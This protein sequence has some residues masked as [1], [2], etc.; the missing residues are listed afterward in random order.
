MKV[1]MGELN[2]TRLLDLMNAATSKCSRVTAAVAY[3]TQSSPFFEHCLANKIFL[4]FIGLLDED[5]A[6]GVGVLEKLLEAG[7]LAVNPRLIKGHFHSKI[8]WWHGH[9]AYIGSANLTASAWSS[10]VECGVFYEEDEILGTQ[11]QVDLEAQFDYLRA[12]SAPVTKE[13][14]AA[15]RKLRPLEEFAYRA[16]EKVRNAF[17]QATKDIPDHKGLVAAAQP[18]AFTRFTVEWNDTL[19]LLRGLCRDFQRLNKRPGW[20]AQSA[21]PTVHF[22]QFLHAY[23]YVRVRGEREDGESARAFDLVNR[24]Y[25]KNRNN[26]E[27]ALR[28]AADWWASLKEA[29][30]GEDVFISTIA[31]RVQA[32]FEKQ[33]LASWTVDDFKNTFRDVHAFATHARQVRNS[34][35]GLPKDHHETG[36]ERV[37]RLSDWLWAQARDPGQ[38]HIH[39]LLQYLIWGTSPTNMVER[40][41]NV[42]RDERW[43]YERLGPSSLGE[44]IGWARPD[45]FP[46]RNNRTNKALRALGYDVTL[47]SDS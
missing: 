44:A 33:R 2:G 38:H 29:P 16:K 32:A 28:E 18:T 24:A 35:F 10:N 9:G 34:V 6:V 27:A 30:F 26:K 41:W 7:P 17:E 8:I 36:V 25:E 47:F 40:L 43:R 37:H 14:V 15:L 42:T 23:Y 46:P 13:L 12:A 1:V 21:N 4:D 11:I 5:C 22:D 20:V 31:P 45:D 19:Q 39:E 3:A